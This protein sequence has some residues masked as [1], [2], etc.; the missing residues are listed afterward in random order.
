MD[1]ETSD[2]RLDMVTGSMGIVYFKY[3]N[4]HKGQGNNKC[5]RPGQKRG[6]KPDPA[7]QNSKR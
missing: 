2:G 7:V 3:D 1:I 5:E 6:S 4:N